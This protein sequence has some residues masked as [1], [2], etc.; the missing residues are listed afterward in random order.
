MTFEKGDY[1]Y[2]DHYKKQ[3][4]I[5]TIILTIIIIGLLIA[6]R[7]TKEYVSAGFLVLG[8]LF[9]LP[10]A[11]MVVGF[12]VVAKYHSYEST[13]IEELKEVC[14][15]FPYQIYIFDGV[16]SST[17]Q[18]MYLPFLVII[19]NQ[20]FGLMQHLTKKVTLSGTKKYIEQ[21]LLDNG[22]NASV[23]LTDNISELKLKLSQV[24]ISPDSIYKEEDG[25]KIRHI[26]LTF[27]V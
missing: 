21:I 20:I 17:E 7:F 15:S 24:T 13:T 2:I 8:I 14:M 10:A 6:S 18:I 1:G 12:I 16:V 3:K 26:I 27:C 11:K 5:I 23:Y 25:D 4:I 19:D 22:R 9:V